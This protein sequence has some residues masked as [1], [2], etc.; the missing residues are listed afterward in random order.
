MAVTLS[1]C[2]DIARRLGLSD[3]SAN[4]WNSPVNC[5]G[6]GYYRCEYESTDLYWNPDC[7]DNTESNVDGE[8]LCISGIR[9]KQMIFVSIYL[10]NISRIIQT[11]T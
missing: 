5:D 9:K 4:Y 11:F 2:E 10:R 7:N 8:N 1:E 6:Q 3:T